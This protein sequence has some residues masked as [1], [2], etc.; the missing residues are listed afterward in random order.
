MMKHVSKGVYKRVSIIDYFTTRKR[1]IFLDTVNVCNRC[2]LE[3][4]TNRAEGCY[5]CPIVVSVSFF[6]FFCCCCCFFPLQL[7][8]E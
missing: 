2:Q 4:I 8:G 5:V 1:K 7:T 3:R 6:F